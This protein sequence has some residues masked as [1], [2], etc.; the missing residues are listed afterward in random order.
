MS[1]VTLLR[2]RSV[3]GLSGLI[4]SAALLGVGTDAGSAGSGS[5]Q[6]QRV[7]VSVRTKG[8]QGVVVSIPRGIACPDDCRADFRRGAEVTLVA[9]SRPNSRLLRWQGACSGSSAICAFVAEPGASVTATFG[10]ANVSIG[11][12]IQTRYPL[13]VTVSGPGRVT[14][15]PVG[16]DCPPE[17]KCEETF[18]KGT[19]VKLTATPTRNGYAVR[20]VSWLA[21]CSGSSC[22][23]EM[24]ANVDVSA[25]FRKP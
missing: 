15:S 4:L 3:V 18:K 16:I 9:G 7:T 8:T 2:R 1:T 17:S 25:T 5:A 10:R 24:D 12:A 14:S 20:W 22:A 21:R 23:V 19:A 13:T 6:V 11:G